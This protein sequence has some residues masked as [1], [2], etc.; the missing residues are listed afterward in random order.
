MKIALTSV[1]CLPQIDVKTQGR[2]PAF[3]FVEYEDARDAAEVKGQV[4]RSLST[5][6][7][8]KRTATV[9][10]NPTGCLPVCNAGMAT[11]PKSK[12]SSISTKKAQRKRE[13]MPG[14]ARSCASRALSNEKPAT[15]QVHP[16]CQPQPAPQPSMDKERAKVLAVKQQKDASARELNAGDP[17]WDDCLAKTVCCCML[18]AVRRRDGVEFMGNR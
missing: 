4:G 7:S 6:L 8:G 17:D 12:L 15:S 11:K 1:C 2:P 14:P 13:M 16:G 9:Y 3:A 18:Q 10:A 5:A